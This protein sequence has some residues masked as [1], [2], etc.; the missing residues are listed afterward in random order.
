[1][2]Q[3]AAQ[4]LTPEVQNLLAAAEEEVEAAV[5]EATLADADLDSVLLVAM[6]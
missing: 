6:E 4:T 1:M 5:P 3:C 2:A